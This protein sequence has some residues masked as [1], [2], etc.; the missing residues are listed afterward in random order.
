MSW[1]KALAERA[2]EEFDVLLEDDDTG[3]LSTRPAMN[4]VK[5]AF[6]RAT[7]APPVPEREYVARMMRQAPESAPSPR[8]LPPSGESGTASED[9]TLASSKPTPI[10]G[11]SPLTLDFS[12]SLAPPAPAAAGATALQFTGS[13][14]DALNLAEARAGSIKP[15]PVPVDALRE[16]RDRFDVGDF[17]GALAAAE[18][19]LEQ[20]PEN[21]D[22]VV[23]A[24]HCREKLKQMYI[25]RLG[26]LRRTP[27]VSSTPEQLRWL[28]LDHR[29]G[30]LLSLVD[31]RSTLD[32]VL[33]MS[34]MGE[35]DALRLLMQL[36]QQNVLK[37]V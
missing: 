13:A 37:V 14:G 2:S 29:A 12:D 35:L 3:P 16:I 28:A 36:M 19:V 11:L 15:G 6:E 24:Q 26:G 30:F 18:A 10:H 4:A 9:E 17:S 1:A 20:H 33:D 8:L 34:G 7:I 27:H 32:E 22:A 5:G 23:Y 25:A 21:G 31:G